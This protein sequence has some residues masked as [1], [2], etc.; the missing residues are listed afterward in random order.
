M[1][2]KLPAPAA[3]A[4]ASPLTALP[5]VGGIDGCVDLLAILQG[6]ILS[7]ASPAD[8]LP[9][10][11]ASADDQPLPINLATALRLADARPLVIAAAAARVAE[12]A[13][14]LAGA[15]VLW[16]PNVFLGGSYYRHDGGGAGNSGMEFING[17]NQL[18]AGYGLTAVV[19]PADAL[20]APLALQQVLLARKIEVQAARN[21]ALLNV[22]EAYFNVQQA[23]GRLA[24]TRDAVARGQVLVRTIA[25]L[26][27]A[28]APPI[29]ADRARAQLAEIEQA[30]TAA[31]EQWRVASADLTRA[32]RLRPG[33]VVVPLEPPHLQVTL[34]SPRQPIDALIPIGLT[35][36][37]ELAA[38][39]ALV[40]ATL[41]RLR[42]ERLRPLIPSLVLQGDA[43]PASPGGYLT[44]GVFYSDVGGQANPLTARNDV[45]VQLLW[46]LRNLG[47]GNKALVKERLAENQRALLDLYDVQDRVAAEIAQAHARLQSA[48]IRVGQAETALKNAQSTYEGNLKGLAQTT[49]SGDLLVLV[50][51][52]QEAVAALTLLLRAYDNYF[53]SVGDYNRAQ[54][55]L[56][57]ALGYP[58]AVLACERSPGP[59]LPVDT[60][61]PADMAPVCP[62]EPCG[63]PH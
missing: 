31:Y 29:E 62:P 13:A 2:E 58:A 57:R 56:F 10:E 51:R 15:D 27:K 42:Q 23:R 43:T 41:V 33:A 55:R 12:A 20:F 35:N 8:S 5:A 9:A 39:Q 61:R 4:S 34:L 45:S 46:E 47:L 52:P 53:L 36:R 26:G 16:L 18:M 21:D 24:G 14:A 7:T 25:A 32:L 60:T 48:A 17:R 3:V 50:V 11:Q 49:R 44:G 22:A 19:S 40:Q 63:C 6:P 28:L 54:F 1:T 37:P 59:L 30:A 38:Q